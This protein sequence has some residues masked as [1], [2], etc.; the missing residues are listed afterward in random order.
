MEALRREQVSTRFRLRL[1]GPTW[2]VLCS[3]VTAID[4]RESGWCDKGR[5][6]S[7]CRSRPEQNPAWRIILP[8]PH[9]L[10]GFA[11][12]VEQ[13]YPSLVPFLELA[14]GRVIVA[15]DGA[16]EIEPAADGKSLRVVWRRWALVGSKA[17]QLVDPHITSEV[18]WR[19]DGATLTRDETFR[20]TETVTIR[21]WWVAVPTTAERS[22]MLAGRT[23]ALGHFSRS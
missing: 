3:F 17:G 18:V 21:R 5:C 13:V 10:P 22:E 16:D 14:D 4:R 2:R 15:T 20:S 6:I 11:N 19:L 8:A 23:A 7:L 12:P 1:C 9:G